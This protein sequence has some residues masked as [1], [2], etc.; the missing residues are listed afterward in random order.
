MEL[1]ELNHVAPCAWKPE[2]RSLVL[3]QGR[4]RCDVRLGDMHAAIATSRN[5]HDAHE[6]T[7]RGVKSIYGS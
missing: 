4:R 1:V 7:R 5:Q 6:C 3:G 2:T